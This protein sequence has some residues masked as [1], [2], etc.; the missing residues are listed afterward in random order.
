MY[1]ED[2]TRVTAE[3]FQKLASELPEKVK[4][5][6]W[7]V[8][9]VGTVPGLFCAMKCINNMKYLPGDTALEGERLKNHSR[10]MHSFCKVRHHH[11][12]KIIVLSEFLVFKCC[13][14]LLS[15]TSC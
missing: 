8:N 1:G 14:I 5:K 2:V 3:T 12:L 13:K 7:S 15:A 6:D 9:K 10:T 11:R 4:D